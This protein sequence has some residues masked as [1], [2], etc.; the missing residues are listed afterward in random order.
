[1]ADKVLVVAQAAG[2]EQ[3]ADA[4]WAQAFARAASA[5]LA[6]PVIHIDVP[7]MAISY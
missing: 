1:M 3:F 6:K 5:S 7:A 2:P 4:A